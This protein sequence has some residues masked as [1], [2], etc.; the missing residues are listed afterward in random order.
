MQV[1]DK[2]KINS[3]V[4]VFRNAE[5]TLVEIGPEWQPWR[6]HIALN[7]AGVKQL[8]VRFTAEELTVI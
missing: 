1:G 8:P 6:F 5:G 2:V 7:L 3:D 4:P